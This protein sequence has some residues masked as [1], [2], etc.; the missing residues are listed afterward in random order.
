MKTN[1]LIPVSLLLM[2]TISLFNS[3]TSIP[4]GAVAVSSF[5]KEKYLG[6]WYEI[7]RMDFK[8]ERGLNNTT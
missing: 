4:K 6:K 1:K 8:F 2:V 3:C 7:A 5:D